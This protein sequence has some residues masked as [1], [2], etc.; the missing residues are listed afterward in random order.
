MTAMR[1]TQIDSYPSNFLFSP[2][3]QIKK[4]GRSSP[5]SF[6]ALNHYC[7]I[8]DRLS[9]CVSLERIARDKR[10]EHR[11]YKT[12]P[13]LIPRTNTSQGFFSDVD[14]ST[15]ARSPCSRK[16]GDGEGGIYTPDHI[17][18]TPSQMIKAVERAHDQSSGQELLPPL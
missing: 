18:T 17:L 11:K 13:C 6:A 16:D 12:L 1:K 4:K 7:V 2:A 9:F 8:S 3:R 10:H 5:S 14:C 15:V